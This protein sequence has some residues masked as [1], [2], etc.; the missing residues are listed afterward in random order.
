MKRNFKI[1]KFLYLI[2]LVTG[3]GFAQTTEPAGFD[4]DVVDNTQTAPLNDYIA[5]AI[6][7]GVFLAFYSIQRNSK[8]KNKL[9]KH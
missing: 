6:V 9:F 2:L 7:L 8:I 3:F 5:E 4:E 1:T